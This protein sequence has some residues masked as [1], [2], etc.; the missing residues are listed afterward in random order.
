MRHRFLNAIG[1]NF[2][3]MPMTSHW[4]GEAIRFLVGG[5]LNA[6]V[7]YG[8]Y[9]LLLHWLSYEVAYAISYV[10]GIVVSYVFNAVYVF[11]QPMRWRS[12]LRYPLVYLLQFLLGLALLKLLIGGLH[13]SAW[14]A[15]LMVAVLTIPVTF[16]ASRFILRTN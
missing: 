13:I 5:V 2:R 3:Q 9:L 4:S 7:S 10:I 6:A 16:L 8:T 11:R 15:P 1:D 14:L 12:A